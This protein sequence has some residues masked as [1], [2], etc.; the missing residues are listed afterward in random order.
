M[1]QPAVCTSYACGAKVQHGPYPPDYIDFL[2]RLTEFGL[3]L[4]P[5]GAMP[6][7]GVPPEPAAEP[8]PAP[9]PEPQEGQF[10]I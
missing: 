6:S 9:E 1:P 7:E 8:E 4:V 5:A 10:D 3:C 2:N